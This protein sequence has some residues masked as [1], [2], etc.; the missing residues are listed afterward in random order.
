[1]AKIHDHPHPLIAQG[2][3]VELPRDGATESR[4]PNKET[5]GP[6][7]GLSPGAHRAHHGERSQQKRYGVVIHEDPSNSSASKATTRPGISS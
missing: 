5:P 7:V 2:D 4:A 6:G 3:E 1:M